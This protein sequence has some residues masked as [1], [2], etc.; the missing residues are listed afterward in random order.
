MASKI[1]SD[2]TKRL[3]SSPSKSVC[4]VTSSTASSSS[5]T[6]CPSSFW[7]TWTRTSKSCIQFCTYCTK[8]RTKSI[9]IPISTFPKLS[10]SGNC[11]IKCLKIQTVGLKLIFTKA[12]RTNF[13]PFLQESLRL[14]I[15]CIVRACHN[16]G[17]IMSSYGG[18][19]SSI[20][21]S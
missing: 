16:Y 10:Q 15:Y 6:G 3:K 1:E 14:T 9:F 12:K 4:I 20:R 8:C 17:R 21:I 18:I 2:E 5:S 11:Q 19:I 13:R 7:S